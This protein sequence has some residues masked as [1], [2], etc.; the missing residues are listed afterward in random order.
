[1]EHT[2]NTAGEASATDAV[3]R[4]AGGAKKDKVSV[5]FSLLSAD[6]VAKLQVSPS[7]IQWRSHVVE[8]VYLCHVVEQCC[9][10][11]IVVSQ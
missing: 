7:F 3:K 2:A 11:T 1:M 4:Q 10:S 9:S 8:I 5:P 6:L